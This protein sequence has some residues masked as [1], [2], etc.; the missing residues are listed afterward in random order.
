MDISKKLVMYWISLSLGSNTTNVTG[1]DGFYYSIADLFPPAYVERQKGNVF[2]G[3]SLSVHTG[4]DTPSPSHNTSTGPMPFPGGT[5]LTGPRSLLGGGTPV[6]DGGTTRWGTLLARSGQGY[7][8]PRQWGTVRWGTPSARDGVLLAGDGVPPNRTEEGVFAM[9]RAVC[10]LRS[11]RRTFLFYYIFVGFRVLWMV[12][13]RRCMQIG[14]NFS[15]I[16]LSA[17]CV[18]VCVCVRLS[19]WAVTFKPLQLRISFSVYRY[20]LPYLCQA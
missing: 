9:R 12:N 3:I 5:P 20:T 1:L 7:L 4:R 6:P 13:Y 10:L 18:C 19:V 16:C 8:S 14:N 17:L 11:R 2:T 15:Q